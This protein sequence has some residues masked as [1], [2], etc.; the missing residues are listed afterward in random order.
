MQNLA[1][2]SKWTISVSIM[3]SESQYCVWENE[4][5]TF[6]NNTTF[7]FYFTSTKNDLEYVCTI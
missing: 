5:H 7:L 1:E 6:E 2:T 3:S 4:K